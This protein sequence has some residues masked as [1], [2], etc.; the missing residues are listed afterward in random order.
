[1]GFV[2]SIAVAADAG[3]LILNRILAMRTRLR[4]APL[5]LLRIAARHFRN[6]RRNLQCLPIRVCVVSWQASQTVSPI[7]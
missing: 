4:V 3:R 1:V 2:A 7:W 5:D 6:F